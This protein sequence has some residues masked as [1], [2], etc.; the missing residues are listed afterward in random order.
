MASVDFLSAD[1]DRITADV[2]RGAVADVT[3]TW[4]S[5]NTKIIVFTKILQKVVNTSFLEPKMILSK[6]PEHLNSGSNLVR[7]VEVFVTESRKT[8]K[9]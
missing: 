2:A 3:S 9:F 5:E 1:F 8:Q 7:S 4:K 6:R